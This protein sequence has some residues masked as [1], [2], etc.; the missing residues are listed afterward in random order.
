MYYYTPV[1]IATADPPLALNKP[2]RL[3][4][5]VVEDSLIWESKDPP[6]LGFDVTDMEEVMH[7]KFSGIL[8]PLFREGQSAVIEGWLETP[9]VFKAYEVLAK[10]DEKYMPDDLAVM[11][12]NKTLEKEEAEAAAAA[13]AAPS[14]T[15]V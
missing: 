14:A 4:G 2:F 5:L 11:I 10:H 8:P 3:G 15:T 9:T 1:Q 6:V 13:A 7:V 12:N